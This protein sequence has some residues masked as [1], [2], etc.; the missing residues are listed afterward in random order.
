MASLIFQY[1]CRDG[2]TGL[3]L[4]AVR[5]HYSRVTPD[6]GCS[7][8]SSVL[9]ALDVAAAAAPRELYAAVKIQ[10]SFRMYLQAKAF[11]NVRLKACTIQRVFRGYSTRKRLERERQTTQHRLYL[12]TVFNIFATRIQATFRGYYSRKT[13]FNYYAQQAY[14]DQVTTRSL[15]VLKEAHHTRVEQDKLR[16]AESQR[17]HARTYARRTAQ[18][19]HTVSTCS[20]P[21]VYLRPPVPSERLAHNLHVAAEKSGGANFETH[22]AGDGRAGEGSALED[23]DLAQAAVLTAGEK[24]EEDIRQNSRVARHH[25]VKA[26]S[27]ASTTP[28]AALASASPPQ[29]PTSATQSSRLPAI[30]SSGRPSNGRPVARTARTTD[31]TDAALNGPVPWEDVLAT[32]PQRPLV[33]KSQHQPTSFSNTAPA[34]ATSAVAAAGSSSKV[35]SPAGKGVS[36]F[37]RKFDVKRHDCVQHALSCSAGVSKNGAATAAAV[38][39]GPA[40]MGPLST[41]KESAALEHSVDQKLIKSVHGNAVFKV[42]AGR[43][44]RVR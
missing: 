10:A 23:C 16:S 5:H 24:L 44:K 8:L 40:L 41:A 39:A 28:P 20:I 6:Y 22:S 11:R 1:P 21:S 2:A 27:H 42:P 12:Q 18:M 7:L 14:I 32:P 9:E 43:G 13:R 29:T 31:D 3:E 15:N 4:E 33:S 35:T 37:H 26:A 19:H 25:R 30:T 34:A 36:S 17:V 38:T